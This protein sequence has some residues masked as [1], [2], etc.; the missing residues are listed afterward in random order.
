MRT[1]TELL[2][3]RFPAWFDGRHAPLTRALVRGYE[4]FARIDALRDFV[5]AHGHLRGLAFVEAALDFLDCRY[6]VDPI[7]HERIP[8]QGRVLVLANHPMGGIDA[9]LLLACVG[10][11]RPDLR[12]VANDWLTS[13][14]GLAPL[15]LPVPVFGARATR[16]GVRALHAA[17]EQE[18]AVLMFPAAEVS[19]LGWSGV[20]DARWRD[21]F[22][23]LA[24]TAHAPLLPVR[25]EGRNSALFYGASLLA[26]SL[27]TPLLPRELSARAGA[28]VVI[29]IGAPR[30]L[31][32][33]APPQRAAPGDALRSAVY[34]LGRRGDDWRPRAA[35]LV[36]RPPLAR[37]RAELDALPCLGETGDGKRIHAGRLASDSPLLRELGRL[38]ELSFR[39]VGEG[40]GRRFDT[41]AYDSWYEHIV[42]W[43]AQGCE[44]AGAYR[45][46]RCA[47]ALAQRG[48]AGLYTASLFEYGP[49][50][51]PMLAQGVELGRSFIAPPYQN[52]RSLDTL[53]CG[54]G[55]WLRTQPDV[56]WLFG[57]VSISA[58]LPRRAREL[59]V[60]YYDRFHRATDASARAAVPFR[61][62]RRVDEFDAL[63]ADTAMAL[64]RREL[65][66]LGARIPVLY[67]QY[68]ELCEPGGVGFL[69]FGVDP[70]FSDSVDGLIRVDLTRLRASRHARWLAPPAQATRAIDAAT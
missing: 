64:L 41:D 23:R 5:A 24:R 55:A 52:S 63:D 15:L 21:G 38:R 12:I 66:A 14:Q 40:T 54:I 30:A 43:D 25:I 70:A 10:R 20:R 16:E 53:W 60:A 27:G 3:A 39:R 68:V 2:Q 48:L 69:S 47:P 50:L 18:Q 49:A 13:L 31:D 62:E 11:V 58:A 32:E 59:L 8:E 33:L 51:A 9:L 65:Q 44:V 22:A 7:E 4:R 36:H 45:A 29:R 6:L 56:R 42:L 37:I 67:R 57:P 28:R 26:R 35:P 34:R 1:P 61:F 19:R 46:L 17:L